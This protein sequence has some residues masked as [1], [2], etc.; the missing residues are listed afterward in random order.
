MLKKCYCGITCLGEC[1]QSFLLLA[2]RLYWGTGFL[3]SGYGKLGNAKGVAVFFADLG[4]PFPELNAYIA[5]GIEFFGGLLLIVGLFSRV[6]AIPL[7]I[8]MIVAYFT[9]H[10]DAI[11]NILTA[12]GVFVA[13]SPFNYMLAAL[14][15][16]AFGPGKISL[17]YLLCK[18][19]FQ[20]KCCPSDKGCDIEKNKD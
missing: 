6:A 19:F 3:L 2:I 16:L 12:P 14:I 1:L 5:G 20:K 9:A 13:Q 15:I 4:I 7:F 17:D 10:S 18:L 8:V 11:Q